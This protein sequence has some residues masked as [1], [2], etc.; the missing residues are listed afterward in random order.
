LRNPDGIN[1]LFLSNHDTGRSAGFI[2]DLDIRKL[3]AAIYLMVPG[4]PFI[5]YGEE[6]G[7]T[8][9]GIDENKRTAMLW[10][11]TDSTGITRNPAGAENVRPPSAGVKEQLADSNSLLNYYRA[12][13]ALKAKHPDIRDGEVVKVDMDERGVCAIR[14][15]DVVV[16]H[17]L[18]GE[19]VQVRTE[20]LGVSLSG[21]LSPTGSAV[22]ERGGVLTLP[23]YATAVLSESFKWCEC[24]Q[25]CGV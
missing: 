15:G 12:V 20:G 5:Y 11:S 8:G 19:S 22:R 16:M 18:T 25:V 24:V 10:S 23:P 14:T 6:I 1:C 9:S 2:T 3:A 4:T 17:N 21:S 13:L 7:M